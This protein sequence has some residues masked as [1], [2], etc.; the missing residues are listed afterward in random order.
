MGEPLLL[1]TKL[2]TPRLRPG[3]VSRPRLAER[4]DAG[5]GCELVLISAPAGFGKTTL[6]GEWAG[7]CKCRLA[8]LSL[9]EDDNDPIRFITYFIAALQTIDAQIGI[10]LLDALQSRQPPPMTEILTTLINQIADLNRIPAED[11]QVDIV[12]VLDDYHFVTAQA[13][14]DILIFLLD[15]LPAMMHLVVAT[16]ADP[17]LPVARLRGRG[18]VIEMRQND[19]RFTPEEAAQFLNQVMDLKLSPQDV[20]TLASRTDGWIAGLQMAAVS[21]QGRN[22]IGN[23]IQSF[24]GSNRY[25]LD[26]LLEEVLHR[27]PIAIQAFLL[28]TSILDRLTAPLCEAVLGDEKIGDQPVLDILS[29]EITL[30]TPATST[31]RVCQAVLEHLERANLFLTPLDDE[32]CWFRYHHLFSD[33]LSQRLR[34]AQPDLELL[35]HS[36]AS[37][38]CERNGLMTEAIDHALAAGD[39][40]RAARLLEE[41]TE[42]VMLSSEVATFYRWVEMLPDEIVHSRP[43]LCIYQAMAQLLSARSLEVAE[44]HLKIAE[45]ADPDANF[46]GELLTIRGLIAAYQGK[47]EV[48]LELGRQAL[49]LLPQDNLF[50]RSLIA[51]YLG[52]NYFYNGGILIAEQTLEQ[53]LAASQ[54]AGNMTNSVLALIHLAEIAMI[55]GKYHHSRTI[56]ERALDLATTPLGRRLPIAGLPMVGM[57]RLFLEWNDLDA[58]ERYA[59][60]GIELVRQWGEVGAINGYILLAHVRRIKLD[61]EG[62]RQELRTANQVAAQFDAMQLDDAY[63]ALN[64][65][66]INVALGD[67]EAAQRWAKGRHFND[68]IPVHEMMDILEYLSWL[69]ILVA[70][71][72]L[73][74]ALKVSSRLLE[75]A[76]DLNMGAIELRVLISRARIFQAQGQHEQ[77]QDAM[78][79][80]LSIAAPEGLMRSFLDQGQEMARLVYE[81]ADRGLA[82]GFTGRLLAAF[83][84]EKEGE[85]AVSD[86]RAD[87][88]LEEMI[89]P[90]SKREIEV[91]QLIAA[92]LS[93]RQV[94][95]KLYLSMSTVKA[96]TYNIYSKLGVHSRTQAVAKA[97]ALG[98]LAQSKAA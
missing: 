49:E 8:W 67:F 35:L 53:A 32:R 54:K 10:G 94:A 48:S 50:F 75:I 97:R 58:A 25:I 27:Q 5:L 42:A 52:L 7:R 41:T 55:R 64:E 68:D 71:G 65:A 43:L 77:A 31:S 56:Y 15:H 24:S 33:L 57:G 38:W 78:E 12:L 17:P 22:D 20:K 87:T 18:Q 98:I 69:T 13:I 63:V 37:V 66:M 60:E 51:G 6:L 59:Q 85:E 62:S 44:T 36:R 30:A 47:T 95:Q 73:E 96:H 14:H 29:Q 81:A 19:L 39:P 70:E 80:A 90:L 89:E 93:N 83:D 2:Y 86:V 28:R 1:Q 9:D 92:G 21:M 79:R 11:K 45:S 46:S 61:V 76:Q 82:P 72:S 40:E 91:L 74:R 16:R 84:L 88:G 3:L 34:Q 26:Y 23:F 4:L